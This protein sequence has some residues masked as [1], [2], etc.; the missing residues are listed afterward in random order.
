MLELLAIRSPVYGVF[1]ENGF[2]VATCFPKWQLASSNYN[3]LPGLVIL[4]IKDL[5]TSTTA[6]RLS[7]PLTVHP[8][9]SYTPVDMCKTQ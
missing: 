5:I 8:Y 7:H 9:A 4:S 2:K 6:D 1:L 3:H